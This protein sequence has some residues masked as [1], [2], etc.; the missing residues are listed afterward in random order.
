MQAFMIPPFL[1]SILYSWLLVW[2]ILAPFTL[3]EIFK[4]KDTILNNLKLI[5]FLGITSVGFLILLLII[6]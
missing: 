6:L 3:P 5:I 1:F 2:I 4:Y